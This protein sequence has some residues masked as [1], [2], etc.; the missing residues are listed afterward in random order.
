MT[1]PAQFNAINAV[2]APGE[3]T[4]PYIGTAPVAVLAPVPAYPL[5]G[6]VGPGLNPCVTSCNP[7]TG[8]CVTNCM[9]PWGVTPNLP[10][11]WPF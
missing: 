9:A 5:P 7:A 3:S 6:V 11:E 1:T 2:A 8:V 10:Y 4:I